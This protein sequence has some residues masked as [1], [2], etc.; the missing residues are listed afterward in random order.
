MLETRLSLFIFLGPIT[1]I[2][3][4]TYVHRFCSCYTVR[5]VDKTSLTPSFVTSMRS[6]SSKVMPTT[7]KRLTAGT[8]VF[9]GD[10]L[11]GGK[12]LPPA[13]CKPPG[14]TQITAGTSANSPE[15]LFTAGTFRFARGIKLPLANNPMRR[16]YVF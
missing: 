16:R 3:L 10:H 9:A 12:P 7:R 1:R 13:H 6:Q 2:G 8:F 11:A 4:A 14:V 5:P 15:V